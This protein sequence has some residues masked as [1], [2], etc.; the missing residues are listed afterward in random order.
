MTL[1]HIGYA[2]VSETLVLFG[3]ND[4]TCGCQVDW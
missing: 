1:Y 4:V 3:T 2:N